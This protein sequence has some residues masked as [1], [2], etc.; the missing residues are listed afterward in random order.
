MIGMAAIPVL[1]GPAARS[2]TGEWMLKGSLPNPPPRKTDALPL[3]DQ[4]NAGGW[5]KID[6]LSDEFDATEL[7]ERKWYP[8]N[9]EWPGRPPAAFLPSN[10][11]VADGKLQLH[12]RKED[13]PAA[14]KSKGY[15]G[16]TCGAVQG[17]QRIRYGYFEVR[18]KPMRAA[19]SSAFWFYA[20]SPASWTE[21]DVYEIWAGAPGL[22]RIYSTNLHMFDM[23]K[24]VPDHAHLGNW[25]AP[26]DL[27]ADYHVY[28]MEWNKDEIL[29]FVDGVLIRRKQNTLWHEPLSLNLDNEIM[30][31]I[32]GVPNDADLPAVYSVDYVRAFRR[33]AKT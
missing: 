4:D 29:F 13:P 27:A 18:S 8:I 26:F 15:Y 25:D 10:V 3:S 9:P 24:G 19:A 22:E 16:W 23:P 6:D 7:D 33:S 21:I 11:T 1:L 31:H 20:K 17:R 2:D 5:E 28:G 14:M 30:T 32:S 12:M